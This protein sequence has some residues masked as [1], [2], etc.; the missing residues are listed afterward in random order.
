MKKLILLAV[1]VGLRISPIHSQALVICNASS[2]TACNSSSPIGSGTQGEPLWKSFGKINE[3]FLSWYLLAP[4][5]VFDI[6]KYGAKCD[7]S[8]DDTSAI[9]AAAAAVS[10]SG[11]TLLFTAANCK[12]SNTFTIGSNVTVSGYGTTLTP[13]ISGWAGTANQQTFVLASNAVNVTVQGFN[14]AYPVSAGGCQIITLSP[15]NSRVLIKDNQS[16]NCGDFSGNAGAKDLIVT[17]NRCYN[18]TNACY[19]NW[20]GT[21][22]GATNVII[23][24]NI[25]TA[26]G[27]GSRCVE[28]TGQTTGHT[29]ATSSNVII[30]G[31]IITLQ[32]SAQQGINVDGLVAGCGGTAAEKYGTIADNHIFM[33]PGIAGWG[34]L[35]RFCANYW[36]VHDNVIFSDGTDMTVAAIAANSD[37]TSVLIHNNIAYNWNNQTSGA[38]RGLFRN[39][40]VGG[41]LIFNECFSCTTATT[42]VGATDST[43]MSFGNDT[44]SGVLVGAF[45]TM[46][47]TPGTS[48]SQATWG[49]AGIALVAA[50]GTFNDTT[51]GSGGVSNEVAYGFGAPTFTNT[52]GTA[53]VLGQATTARFAAPICGAGWASCTNLYSISSLGRFL[54]NL[55]ADIAGASI[56]LNTSNNFATNINT[57]TS[58]GLVTLGGASGGV[59]INSSSA[60][61][62]KNTALI[63]TGT[64][65]TTSGCSVSA[66][67]G[68]AAAGTLT[69]GA[70]TCTV[71]V[72]INGATGLTAPTGWSCDAHDRTAPTVLIGGESSSTTTTASIIIPGGAGTTDV[73][74]FSCT[75]Y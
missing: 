57:G 13:N 53:N 33:A 34:I 31:N 25:C 46:T 44:G 27:S 18:A 73:I 17:H 20:A 39:G 1:L 26:L 75:G 49:T 30:T 68:G 42:L 11:G 55:G 8:T 6:A 67:T 66:T 37:S 24:D 41:T 4:N 15:T 45:G 35:L 69:L 28:F 56:N 40:S 29:A 71:V 58:N 21:G 70:N 63:S 3:N 10:L 74:S 9:T 72:T 54:G 23:T 19:D 61:Y 65:F 52:Q 59:I 48:L 43:T 22:T 64:K 36:D 16:N 32:S 38:D 14:F 12:Y 47:L 7:G 60:G 50:A 62:L 51:T 5:R 2:N